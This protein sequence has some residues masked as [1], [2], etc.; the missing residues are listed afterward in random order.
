[1][2]P[3]YNLTSCEVHGCRQLGQASR[4]KT[5]IGE[6]WGLHPKVLE[7]GN[8]CKLSEICYIIVSYNVPAECE[9]WEFQLSAVMY[10]SFNIH[11]TSCHV[12]IDHAIQVHHRATWASYHTRID[13]GAPDHTGISAPKFT[14]YPPIRTELPTIG[15]V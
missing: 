7:V 9:L 2:A 12:H 11:I 6:T 8:L 5:K 14:L 3:V 13:S 15:A 10:T 1:M 4:L